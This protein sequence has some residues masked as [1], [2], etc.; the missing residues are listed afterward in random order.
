MFVH[1]PIQSELQHDKK[2]R[3]K[4]NDMCAQPEHPPS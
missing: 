3:K 2:M 4:K 1:R